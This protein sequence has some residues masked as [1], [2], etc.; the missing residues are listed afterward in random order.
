MQPSRTFTSR[1]FCVLFGNAYYPLTLNPEKRESD[2]ELE[3]FLVHTTF[4]AS[5]C[6]L[7][8]KVLNEILHKCRDDSDAPEHFNKMIEFHRVLAHECAVALEETKTLEFDPETEQNPWMERL[9][10]TN[11]SIFRDTSPWPKNERGYGF[12]FR[13][14]TVLIWVFYAIWV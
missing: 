14:T 1:Q 12:D 10:K 4:N 2:D 13:M 11:A 3:S 8:L 9:L 7:F 6:L 5:N